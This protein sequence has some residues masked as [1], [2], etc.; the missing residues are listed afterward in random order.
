MTYQVTEAQGD[1]NNPLVNGLI[2][3]FLQ[4]KKSVNRSYSSAG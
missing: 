1:K 2:S 4:S 3:L